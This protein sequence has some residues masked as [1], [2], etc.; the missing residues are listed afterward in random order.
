MTTFDVNNDTDVSLKMDVY[1]IYLR[2]SKTDLEAEKLARAGF[3]PGTKR[4]LQGLLLE[5]DFI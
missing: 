5:K 4:Y 1:A 3:S 2:K